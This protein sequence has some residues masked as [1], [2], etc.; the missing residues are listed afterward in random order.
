MGIE[1]LDVDVHVRRSPLLG[2][3]VVSLDLNLQAF[4]LCLLQRVS[5]LTHLVNLVVLS[6]ALSFVSLDLGS[7]ELLLDLLHRDLRSR[8]SLFQSLLH[9]GVLGGS[10]GVGDL[11]IE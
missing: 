10:V 5:P 9:V 4:S 8:L 6:L 1:F 7:L 3:R 2:V 11:H